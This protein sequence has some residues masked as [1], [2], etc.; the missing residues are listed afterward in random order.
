MKGIISVIIPAAVF[1][2]LAMVIHPETAADNKPALP[3]IVILATGGTI[4][5]TA[6]TSTQMVG[7]QAAKVGVEGLIAAV[8][9]L[10][11]VADV[12]GEQVMQVASQDITLENWMTL[13]ER[14][15]AVLAKPEVDGVVITHGT[16]TMEE[17]AYFLN[18]TVKSRKP[19]VL[20]GAMRPSTAISADG[21]IN[22]LNSVALAASPDSAGKGVMIC[23]DDQISA[24]REATKTNTYNVDTFKSRD[25]G[26]LG[27]MQSH[28]PLFYRLPTRRH[29]VASEFDISSVKSLPR[30]AAIL[31]L[32]GSRGISVDVA[33]AAGVKGLIYAGAGDGSVSKYV[34]PTL[35]DAR[36]KG[37]IVVRSSRTG[38][39]AVER[40]GEVDDDKYDFVTAD[41]LTPQKARIL[42]MLALTKTTDTKEIQRM[43]GEY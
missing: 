25:T 13:W 32:A 29:T 30:V 23:M 10:T 14:V 38:S 21:P 37:I 5:G 8:P 7:Y 26:F 41:N 19:I 35:E 36:K 39:G 6:G 17:T 28:S 3:K 15:T 12:K 20:T 16:D 18:L 33:V 11:A 24:A 9:G 1:I 31:G 43:F 2:M 4:A 34:L 42:L 22:I 40:N 27:L